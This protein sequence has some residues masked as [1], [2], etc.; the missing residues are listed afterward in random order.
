MICS[1]RNINK[2]R[3]RSPGFSK[4]V[5]CCLYFLNRSAC[6]G[7][8]RTN[9][10]DYNASWC[11][12]SGMSVQEQNTRNAIKSFLANSASSSSGSTSDASTD[13]PMAHHVTHSPHARVVTS[14]DPRHGGPQ[15][16]T[17]NRPR[18]MSIS[19]YASHS[20]R[21]QRI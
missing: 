15:L 7:G 1:H 8:C 13:S 5:T 20:Y 3:L 9:T 10:K 11:R 17:D 19:T 14:T 4:A 16:D 21:L 18:S 2:P 6:S 12:F